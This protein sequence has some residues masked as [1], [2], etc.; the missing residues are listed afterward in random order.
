M[1]T[2]F[3]ITLSMHCSLK[4]DYSN[5]SSSTVFKK[6]LFLEYKS[7]IKNARQQN[8]LLLL[9]TDV[10]EYLQAYLFQNFLPKSIREAF[11]NAMHL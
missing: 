6:T 2:K 9:L 7:F 3:N 5:S 4:N 11:T 8:I 1:L 10:T